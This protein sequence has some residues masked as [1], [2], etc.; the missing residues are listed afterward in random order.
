M[1][2]DKADFNATKRT[3]VEVVK[4]V[5]FGRPHREMLTKKGPPLPSPA[6][7]V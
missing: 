6:G 5:E 3:D 1:H 4:E 7:G 2:G